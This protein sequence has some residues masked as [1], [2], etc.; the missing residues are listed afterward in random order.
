MQLYFHNNLSAET[1]ELSEEESAHLRVLRMNI[2]NTLQLTD[3]NGILAK[4]EI[5]AVNKRTYTVHIKNREKTHK[6]QP[7]LHLAI[8]L[9]KNNERIEWLLEKAVEMGVTAFYPF[10]AQRSE[11]KNVNEE[12]L[13]KVA[14]SAAKQSQR[15]HFPIINS[16]QTFDKLIQQNF[17]GSKFICHCNE[18]TKPIHSLLKK[19]ENVLI[20]IGAEGD[21]SPTEIEAALTQN[22]QPIS[23]GNT[24]LR[25]ETAGLYTTA[26]FKWI[27]ETV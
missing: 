10:V 12:R 14:L 4:A 20:L 11:R 13:K 21:F 26:S 8:S 3:G 2:G 19:G 15:T 6:N 25:S 1:F 7:E 27:N 9:L 23:L 17:D 24:R 16:V 5:I 18:D 22:F